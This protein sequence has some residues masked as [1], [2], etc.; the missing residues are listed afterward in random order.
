MG[1]ANNN[2]DNKLLSEENRRPLLFVGDSDS[3]PVAT[4]GMSGVCLDD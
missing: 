1:I 3:V 2:S 4:L